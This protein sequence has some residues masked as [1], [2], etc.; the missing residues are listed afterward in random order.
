MKQLYYGFRYFSGH[1]TTTGSPHS[2]TGH[3]SIA[4][5]LDVFSS[6][7]RLDVWL[8]AEKRTAPC[9][10]E[11]GERVQ[12]TKKEARNHRLGESV[13]DFEEEID[14]QMNL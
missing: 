8:D 2:L 12:L 9:G 3:L 1:A 4:G 13:D 6:Q 14:Y 5:S 11:G 10:C 7:Q